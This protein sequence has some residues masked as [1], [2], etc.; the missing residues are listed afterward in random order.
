MIDKFSYLF[1]RHYFSEHSNSLSST[2][3][4]NFGTKKTGQK[5]SNN[6]F[7]LQII[8]Q[9][10]YYNGYILYGV[11]NCYGLNFWWIFGAKIIPYL[12]YTGGPVF[13][14]IFTTIGKVNIGLLSTY[15]VHHSIQ[16]VSFHRS[17]A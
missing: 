4:C 5:P 3:T 14:A 8:E 2:V 16:S 15:S 17:A 12:F 10:K 6:K 9:T 1:F 11:F 13:R 7:P